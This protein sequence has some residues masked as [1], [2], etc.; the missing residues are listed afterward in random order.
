MNVLDISLL[1]A[2][3]GF[4]L[5]GF[6]FGIIHM[7]GAL[8]GVVVGAVA[9]GR[10]YPMVANWIP[11]TG[12]NAN[13]AK[14]IAFA[15][16]FILV[17]KLVG[18]A[19]WVVEKIFKFIAVIPFLKT[20]NRLLGA[21]LGLLEGTLVLGLVI[22][23]ASKFPAGAAFEMLMRDSPVA[24]ALLPVGKLLAPLLPL[25]VRAAQSLM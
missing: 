12:D 6:W 8:L 10:L 19:F 25:A 3:G 22:Y 23:F 14:I 13:L 5:Y 21:A 15:V 20:F 16:V 1:V 17:N 4:V 9:A 18:L 11:F 24:H 2:L 7:V